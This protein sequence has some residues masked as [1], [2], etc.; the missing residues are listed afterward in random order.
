MLIMYRLYLIINL[1]YGKSLYFAQSNVFGLDNIDL[2]NNCVN[3]SCL[4]FPN[5]GLINNVIFEKHVNYST[6]PHVI[7][8]T[9]LQTIN[10]PSQITKDI[11]QPFQMINDI[12]INN[13]ISS[14]CF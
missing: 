5:L 13:D 3:N 9:L 4:V 8:H 12:N 11:Y 10:L 14:M 2:I 6:F 1:I 7:S